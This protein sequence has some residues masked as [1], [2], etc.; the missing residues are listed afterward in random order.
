M[1]NG[2]ILPPAIAGISITKFELIG[3]TACLEMVINGYDFKRLHQVGNRKLK[4][5]W[6][7]PSEKLEG[8][9]ILSDEKQA[10]LESIFKSFCLEA[11]FSIDTAIA[12]AQVTDGPFA[13]QV[14]T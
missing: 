2:I 11:K 3:G 7:N 4:P 5:V 14:K 12:R 13:E 1:S 6:G 9:E 8:C 10:E